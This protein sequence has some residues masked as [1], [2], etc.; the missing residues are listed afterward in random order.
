MSARW[1]G[2]FAGE[3]ARRP[4]RP[5]GGRGR[6][7]INIEP[8][9]SVYEAVSAERARDVNLNLGVSNREGSLVFYG[10]PGLDCWSVS[11]EVLT[12][13]FGAP[14]DQVFA[15]DVPVSTLAAICE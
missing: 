7:G 6:R 13:H 15:R 10:A 2:D 1:G 5:V 9:P 14:P 11:R 12:G 8:V 3:D 4:A